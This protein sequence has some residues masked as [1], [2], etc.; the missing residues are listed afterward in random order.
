M[1]KK[2]DKKTQRK[3]LMQ[4][5]SDHKY[6]A[7]GHLNIILVTDNKNDATF[8]ADCTE[9]CFCSVIAPSKLLFFSHCNK[10]LEQK[11]W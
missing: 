4:W 3:H 1:N 9:D 2:Q 5:P 11:K 10:N 7:L 6:L 8:P